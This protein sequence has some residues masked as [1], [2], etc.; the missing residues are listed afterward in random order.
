[1]QK[2]KTFGKFP[3][4]LFNKKNYKW[5]KYLPKTLTKVDRY[6]LAILVLLITLSG[7][8]IWHRHFINISH[9]VPNY[10]GTLTEGIVGE[11]KDL[12]KHVARLTGAGLTRISEKGELS[13]DIAKSWKILDDNKTYE[14]KL[15]SNYNA[16]ELLGQIQDKNIWPGIDI[17]APDEQTITFRFKQPFSPFLYTTTTPISSYGPYKIT[18]ENKSQ[19]TLEANP[20]YWQGKPYINTIQIYLYPD[21]NALI[22]AA[23]NGE[24]MGYLREEENDYRIKDAKSYTMSLPRELNLFFNLSKPALQDVNV[25]RN[26]RDNK[27][28]AKKIKLTLVTSST[29]K[30][31]QIAQKIKSSWQALNV[32]L[33]IKTYDDVNLQKDIIPKRNYDVL[34]YGQ[35]YGPDPD[36][37][38]YWHSSQI[39]E[40]GLNLSNFSNKNADKLLEDARLTFDFNL[41]KQKYKEFQTILNQEVP[42]INVEKEKLYY[43]LSNDIRGVNKIYG[44]S[45]ADR[46]L[47][48]TQWYIKSKRVRN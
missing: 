48:V 30:N 42:Y 4:T 39:S 31:E 36:P 27:A 38:P 19:V 15:R 29:D 43:T 22:A 37:Y 3:K 18:N 10:G 35:D 40:T 16:D 33:T 34:L 25:R 23:K 2:L 8:I 14:F 46:F 9:E 20:S 24:I 17:S 7:T 45:E 21:Y 32:N 6:I 12:E 11:P 28:L 13:P 44:S 26:L 1:M 5:L 47:N 41:R